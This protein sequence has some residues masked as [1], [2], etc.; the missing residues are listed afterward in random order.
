V[1]FSPFEKKDGRL[2]VIFSLDNDSKTLII[3]KLYLEDLNWDDFEI[4]SGNAILPSGLIEE[5]DIISDCAGNL[6]LRH[7]PTNI[8]FGGFN[9]D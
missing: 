2:P 6:S 9:F 5:G 3:E 7:I 8:I 1:N 4:C